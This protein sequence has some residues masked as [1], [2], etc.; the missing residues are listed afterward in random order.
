MRGFLVYFI[1]PEE[2]GRT[3][4]HVAI[5]RAGPRRF[6]PHDRMCGFRVVAFVYHQIFRR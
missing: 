6:F 3:G 1:E 4:F 2:Q 5:R